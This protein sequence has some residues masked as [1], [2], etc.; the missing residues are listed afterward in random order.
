MHVKEVA[1][2][3]VSVNSSL[4]LLVLSDM[5]R[6]LD[7]SKIPCNDTLLYG[8]HYPII[9]AGLRHTN[10]ACEYNLVTGWVFLLDADHAEIHFFQTDNVGVEDAR[11]QAGGSD[12]DEDGVNTGLR[13][14][15]VDDGC[16]EEQSRLATK[17]VFATLRKMFLL[18]QPL[19]ARPGATLYSVDHSR[20]G[21]LQFDETTGQCYNSV[22]G[23]YT[24]RLADTGFSEA[25][26]DSVD[27]NILKLTPLEIESKLLGLPTTVLLDT[28]AFI[29]DGVPDPRLP[30]GATRDT[31]LQCNLWYPLR[32]STRKTSCTSSCTR[33]AST[34]PASLRCR[35]T[36][37]CWC[38]RTTSTSTPNGKKSRASVCVT[39]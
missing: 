27:D 24:M 7:P 39:E 19:V 34:R 26:V 28:R 36:S 22:D 32:S 11:V 2:R 15:V 13:G 12:D 10:A 37:P 38:I 1:K 16:P 9:G 4:R 29:V 30:V 8:V 31:Y 23:R 21:T 14:R 3:E 18:V 35:A 17:D 25:S 5:Y 20:Y 33:A 6:S